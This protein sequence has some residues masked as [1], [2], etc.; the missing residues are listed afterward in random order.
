LVEERDGDDGRRL[1][2]SDDYVHHW[3]VD[4]AV[5]GLEIGDWTL[6][7]GKRLDENERVRS[8]IWRGIVVK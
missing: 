6:E 3:V 7:V 8:F 5:G 4:C 2:R 1:G